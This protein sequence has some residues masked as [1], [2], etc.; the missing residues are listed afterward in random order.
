MTNVSV[1]SMVAFLYWAVV[2]IVVVDFIYSVILTALNVKASRLPIPKLLE[3]IYDEEKYRKQQAYSSARRKMGVISSIFGTLVALALFCFGGF[4]LMDAAARSLS[5]YPVVQALIFF[6]IF[7][8]LTFLIDI[9]FGAYSTFVIEEKFGFNKTTRKTFCLDLLKNYLMTIVISGILLAACVWIYGRM[10]EYF[11]LLAWGV[12]SVV[13]LFLQYFYSQLIVPLFNKQTPL[14]E[15]SLRSAIESFATRT[16]FSIKDIY[17]MDGSKRTTHAN[18][19]FAGIGRRR[20]VVLYDTLISQMDE[21]EIVAVLSHE[22]G[23]CRH[24][25]IALQLAVGLASSLLMFFVFSLVIDS[26]A[27]AQAAG[28]ASASFHVNLVVFSLLYSPVNVLLEVV[29]NIISRR[30]ERQAD[31]FSRDNGMGHALA[32]ALKKLSASS[33]SNLT[34]HPFVVFVDYSHPTLFQRV[35]AL[36]NISE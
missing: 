28:C 34:P 7:Y 29:Q 33:L 21:E 2:A 26:Q 12:M 9:P 17:V 25:H 18:A 35:K 5:D 32:C 1:N 19:Y 31:A 10:P 8:T 20:R 22:I 6:G 11:W 14:P 15:G 30:C 23:H 24:H 16:G 4:A 13:T 3:G 36:E 27:F